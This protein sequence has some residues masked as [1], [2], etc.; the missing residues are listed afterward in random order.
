[1]AA[2]VQNIHIGQLEIFIGGTPPTAGID[3]NDPTTS[4]LNA[5]ASGFSA[6]TSGGTYVGFTNG[7]ANLAYKPTFYMVETEQAF[8]E[9]AVVPTGEEATLDFNA[10]EVTYQNMA[11]AFGQGTTHVVTGPPVQNAIHVGSKPTVAT[12]V[13]AGYSR[14]RS[15]T[16]YY[17]VTLYQGYSFNG[18][19]LPFVRR[20]DTKIPIQ[21][22]CLADLSRPIGD[23]LFQIVEYPANPT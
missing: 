15:G 16:G 19:T 18:G 5:M 21:I 20:E 1:M 14:K 4:A 8:A 17:I 3:P 2:S 22:R 10:L 7:A 11:R 12:Q 9:V 6:P 23:Q 13:V